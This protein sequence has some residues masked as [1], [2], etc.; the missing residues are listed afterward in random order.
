[1]PDYKSQTNSPYEAETPKAEKPAAKKGASCFLILI[2]LALIVA[3]GAFLLW[4]AFAL[5]KVYT[6]WGEA[7]EVP[8]VV[9]LSRAEADAEFRKLDLRMEIIDS[10]YVDSAKPGVVMESNP[11]PG[12]KVK[13]DRVIFVTVNANAARQISLPQVIQ[14]SRRQA[15]ASLRG[16]G[17]TNIEEKFVPGEFN[18][19]VL[20]VKDGKTGVTLMSGKRMAVN[21]PIVL[22]VS[23]AT[24]LDSL[25]MVEEA[26]VADSLRM[27]SG[28][29]SSLGQKTTDTPEAPAEPEQTPVPDESDPD[30]WF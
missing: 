14:L 7:I 10:V 23:S 19:L 26:M 25:M 4:A 1:M 21:A 24:L 22:E 17:F 29:G 28:S 12:S 9:G 13:S 16:A 27:L 15:L 8:S 2:N 20:S 6:R 18:D 30:D 5:L 3:V 11:R